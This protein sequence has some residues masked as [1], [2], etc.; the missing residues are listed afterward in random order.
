MDTG[1]KMME[2]L[3]L[4]RKNLPLFTLTLTFSEFSI[5]MNNLHSKCQLLIRIFS[6]GGFKLVF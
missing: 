1:G 6:M 5:G 3:M 4:L 2:I